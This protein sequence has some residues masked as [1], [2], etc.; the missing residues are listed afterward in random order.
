MNDKLYMKKTILTALA[1]LVCLAAHAQYDKSIVIE[2]L[3]KTDTTS[4]GQKIVYP[5]Y[6]NDQITVV[7]AIIPAGT[8]TGWHKHDFPLVAYV[9]NGTVTLETEDGRKLQFNEN[10]SFVE[11]INIYHNGMNNGKEDVELFVVYFGGKEVPL[12]TRK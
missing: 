12:S 5:H 3:L 1:V 11:M 9:L 7:R 10:D 6:D 8:S 2:Q 4:I